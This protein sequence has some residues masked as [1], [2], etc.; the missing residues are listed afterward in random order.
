M[1]N[2]MMKF[3]IVPKFHNINGKINK[4]LEKKKIIGF[5]I[6]QKSDNKNIIVGACTR[7]K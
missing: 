7:T 6:S 4:V 1:M 3:K 5:I 2:Q